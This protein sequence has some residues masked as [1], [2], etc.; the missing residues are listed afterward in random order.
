MSA[1]R[2][3]DNEAQLPVI[4]R[5][6]RRLRL[7]RMYRLKD[8]AAKTG[9]S[10]SKVHAI[11]IGTSELKNEDGERL[12]KLYCQSLPELLARAGLVTDAV[13]HY[14]R[15]I[16][17]AGLLFDL[18]ATKRGHSEKRIMLLIERLDNRK[19]LTDWRVK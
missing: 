10:Q 7:S 11:E 17:S 1:P 3:R 4:G 12:A 16:P 5:Y 19:S 2:V 6:L 14:I 8:V 9:I 15:G 18:I 13:Q